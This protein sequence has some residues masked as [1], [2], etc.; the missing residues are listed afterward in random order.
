MVRS[1]NDFYLDFCIVVCI[2]GLVPSQ[3][4]AVMV[5]SCEVAQELIQVLSLKDK[6]KVTPVL[7]EYWKDEYFA[8]RPPSER[9]INRKLDARGLNVM[10]DWRIC[11]REYIATYYPNYLK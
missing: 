5:K 4:D 10:R 6:V 8:D 3:V 9:L 1:F 7:S 11:L 2:Q